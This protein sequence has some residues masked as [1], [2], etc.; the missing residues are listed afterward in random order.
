MH[1]SGKKSNMVGHVICLVAAVAFSVAA[2]VNTRT[3]LPVEMDSYYYEDYHMPE[4]LISVYKPAENTKKKSSIGKIRKADDIKKSQMYLDF[5]EGK[6][7]KF[8]GVVVK[9]KAS[10]PYDM[11]CTLYYQNRAGKLDHNCKTTVKLP[12]DRKSTRLNS[13]HPTTSRMPSSA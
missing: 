11:R 2:W 1:R 3:F 12:Q 10:F 13:S 4:Q 7:Q 5:R 9:L 8:L 6:E